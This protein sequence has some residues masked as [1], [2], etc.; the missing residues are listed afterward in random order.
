MFDLL[1][2]KSLSIL[3]IITKN[4][5]IRITCPQFLDD[6]TC[7]LNRGGLEGQHGVLAL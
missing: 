1:E 3:L 5:R 6:G 7:A 4:G 2:R